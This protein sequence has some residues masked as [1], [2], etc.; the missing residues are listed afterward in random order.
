[1]SLFVGHVDEVL[2]DQCL[3]FFEHLLFNG[4]LCIFEVLLE[5]GVLLIGKQSGLI[6]SVK[7]QDV[8]TF[9]V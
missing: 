2:L 5:R 6:L 8:F 3:E 1:M 7:L 4:R 9:V